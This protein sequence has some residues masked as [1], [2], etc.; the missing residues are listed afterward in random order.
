MKA[1]SQILGAT[2]EQLREIR[3]ANVVRNTASESSNYIGNMKQDFR[4]LQSQIEDHMDLGATC[5]TDIASN[6]KNFNQKEWVE[7]MYPMCMQLATMAMKIRIAVNVHNQLFPTKPETGLDATDLNFI[8]DTTGV[9]VAPSE[10]APE[11]AAE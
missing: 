7:K 5:T 8:K 6:L 4:N 11:V 2:S 3:V 9:E 1:F 10:P